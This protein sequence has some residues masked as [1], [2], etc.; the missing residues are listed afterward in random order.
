VPEVTTAEAARRLATSRPTIRAL[1]EKGLLEGTQQ[2][3]GSRFRWRVDAASLD[4]FLAEHGPYE[5]R[6]TPK[7]R[8]ERIETELSLLREAVHALGTTVGS[9][10][11]AQ[12]TDD[13]SRER[14]DFRARV[15][16][17]EEAL[18]R[19]HAVAELQRDADAERAAV[20]EHLLAAAAAAE[21]ADSFRR[22]ALSEMEEAL[23]GFTRPGHAGQMR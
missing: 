1:I 8:M 20:V 7:S 16:N 6:R 22:R 2:Q 11:P 13:A 3:W 15:V 12:A 18:A 10:N 4:R 17:V 5:G 21:K 19:A 9:E 14:D 23:A